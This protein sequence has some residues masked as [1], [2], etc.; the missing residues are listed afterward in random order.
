ME[1]AGLGA[2]KLKLSSSDWTVRLV[3]G[4]PRSSLLHYTLWLDS[5]E[6]GAVDLTSHYMSTLV[7]NTGFVDS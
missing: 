2:L 5:L 1:T 3:V 4:L 7:T 6:P